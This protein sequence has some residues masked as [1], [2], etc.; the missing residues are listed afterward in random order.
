MLL[1]RPVVQILLNIYSFIQE[2]EADRFSVMT[3]KCEPSNLVT[4]LRFLTKSSNIVQ[5]TIWWHRIFITDHPSIEKRITYI[6]NLMPEK[7]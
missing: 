7:K 2:Y 3:A 1:I 5:E 6:Q 4:A